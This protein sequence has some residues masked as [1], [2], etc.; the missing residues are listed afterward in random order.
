[1]PPKPT[2]IEQRF[3]TKV[4]KTDGCWL[5][6]G[7]VFQA[8][9]YGQV[10]VNRRPDLAHRVAWRLS[11]GPIPVGKWVLHHCDNH[12]CVR[13]DHL[14][15][16]DQF[17]NMRDM[18]AKGRQWLQRSPARMRGILNHNAKLTDTQGRAYKAAGL[19]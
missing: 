4:R 6:T 17:A 8:N 7:G 19:G 18:A 12:R 15:I 10:S 9:G 1:M 5:W 13:P 11:R 2:P 14:F 3:W 16:G